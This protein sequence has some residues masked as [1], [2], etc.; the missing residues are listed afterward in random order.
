MSKNGSNSCFIA[1]KEH[2]E[3]FNNNP[4]T[5]LINPAKNEVGRISK[6]ILDQINSELKEKLKVNQWKSSKDVI[7]WFDLRQ[8]KSAHTFTVF[9]I[10]DFYPSM[11]ELLLKEAIEF[12]KEDVNVDATDLETILQTRKSLLF[13]EEYTWGSFRCYNG[14][15]RW[16]GDL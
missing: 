5:R 10:K 1:L 3:N 7:S 2:K 15:I 14:S 4:T 13:N 6:V 16:C 11:T 8:N 12:A 9:D